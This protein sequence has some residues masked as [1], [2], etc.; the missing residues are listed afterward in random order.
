MGYC[1]QRLQLAMTGYGK[2]KSIY[3]LYIADPDMGV[4][5]FQLM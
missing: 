2:S 5:Q 4:L 1:Q 3:T